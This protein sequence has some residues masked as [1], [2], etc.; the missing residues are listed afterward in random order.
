MI[1]PHNLTNKFQPLDLTVNKASKAF[2]QNQYNNWFS[3]QVARQLKSGNDPTDMRVSSKLSDLK[4]L[5]ASWIVD[6]YKHMQGE[7]ELILKGFKEAAIYEA[8][9]DAQEIFERVENLFR[10]EKLVVKS[11]LMFILYHFIVSKC[12]YIPLYIIP[13]CIPVLNIPYFLF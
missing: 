11:C 13:H 1:V 9:N 4:P 5:H 8:I 10:A 2:I 3:D 12:L 6:L 7:D